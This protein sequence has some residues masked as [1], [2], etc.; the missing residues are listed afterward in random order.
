MKV[1]DQDIIGNTFAYDGCHKIYICENT[2]DEIKMKDLGYSIY[3][4]MELEHKFDISCSLRFIS[5]TQLT[6]QYVEQFEKA[7]FSY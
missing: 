5:N 2:G 7:V 3:P 6:K 1:N 4:I